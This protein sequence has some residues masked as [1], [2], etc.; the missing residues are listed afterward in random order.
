MHK[1][2]SLALLGALLATAASAQ[3]TPNA[4][5]A[6]ID[7]DQAVRIALKQST[8]VLQAKGT[9][10]RSPDGYSMQLPDTVL[11]RKGMGQPMPEVVRTKMEKA[12]GADFS[13]VRIHVGPEASSIGALAF[14]HGS[15]IYFAAGQAFAPS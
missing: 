4:A 10:Q 8:A 1:T 2:H 14:A 15:D 13:D 7:F 11:R 3:T 6:P 5:T 9:V 12:L